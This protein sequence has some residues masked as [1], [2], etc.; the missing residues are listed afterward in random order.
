MRKQYRRGV[1]CVYHHVSK[2]RLH[3]YCSEFDFRYNTRKLNDYARSEIAL[4]GAVGKRLTYR[5][6]GLLPA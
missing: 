4:I 2:A 1:I 6:A 5:R 3:R